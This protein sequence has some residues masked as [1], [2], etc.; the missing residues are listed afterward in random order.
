VLISIRDGMPVTSIRRATA[1]FKMPIIPNI[2]FSRIT[3][4]DEGWAQSQFDKSMSQPN[5]RVNYRNRTAS[6]FRQLIEILFSWQ[7]ERFT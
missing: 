3:E 7:Q 6:R 5:E 4:M 1:P 2:F